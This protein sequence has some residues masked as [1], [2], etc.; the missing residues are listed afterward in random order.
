VVVQLRGPLFH[1][2]FYQEKEAFG[3]LF[4]SEP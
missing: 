4:E 2:Q 1:L 3:A